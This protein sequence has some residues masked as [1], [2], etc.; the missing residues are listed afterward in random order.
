MKK[1]TWILSTLVVALMSAGLSA[2]THDTD[3]MDQQEDDIMEGQQDEDPMNG[4]EEPEPIIDPDPEQD[5]NGVIRDERDIIHS[6]L[7]L[8]LDTNNDGVITREEAEAAADEWP[9]LIE[10]FDRL[11]VTGNGELTLSE[12][13]DFEP[14]FHGVR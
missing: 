6:E 14:R 11:D 13:E 10:Q 9:E 8:E 2:D 5:T 4:E 12:F 1:N 7:F 3:I